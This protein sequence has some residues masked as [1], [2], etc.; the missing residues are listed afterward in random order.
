LGILLVA[1]AGVY[2]LMRSRKTAGAMALTG[3]A[4]AAFVWLIDSATTLAQLWASIRRGFSMTQIGL[5]VTASGCVGR[6]LDLAAWALIAAALVV[7]MRNQSH[8]DG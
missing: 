6:V 2:G 5:F 7:A 8:A 4:L 1:G 3:S